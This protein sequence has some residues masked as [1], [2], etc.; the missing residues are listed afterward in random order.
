MS[1]RIPA[2]ALF[3]F[4]LAAVSPLQAG[5]I[6]SNFGAGLSYNTGGGNFIGNGLDG[7]G[8]N[9]A[10]GTRSRPRSRIAS[11]GSRYALSNFFGPT[12]SDTLQLA[13]LPIR[14]LIPPGASLS[15]SSSRLTLLARS[16]IATRRSTSPCP[17][18]SH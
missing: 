10:R 6:F 15:L 5:E 9:Y 11:P 13:S 2:C 1:R 16:A 7:S 12:N 3:A 14:A 8:S 18:A 4:L 17:P